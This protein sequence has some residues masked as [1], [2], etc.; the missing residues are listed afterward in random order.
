VDY[1]VNPWTW[2]AIA[3]FVGVIVAIF[4]KFRLEPM[5]QLPL[6][7][8]EDLG[9]AKISMPKIGRPLVE[10]RLT[11]ASNYVKTLFAKLITSSPATIQPNLTEMRD[12]LAKG[13]LFAQRS[14]RDKIIYL[15]DE[16]LMDPNF[17]VREDKHGST[18]IRFIQ[19]QDCKSYGTVDG[20]EYIGI[21]VN[22]SPNKFT[23]IQDKIYDALLGA[24][25]FMRLASVNQGKIKQ[26]DDRNKSLEGL[27]DKEHK[28]HAE[29]RSKLDRAMSALE[30]K[31]LSTTGE[32]KVP[33]GFMAK[34]KD[35]FTWPQLLTAA[36]AYLLSPLIIQSLASTQGWTIQP[37]ATS[38]LTALVTIAGFFV[39]PFLKK[40]LGRWL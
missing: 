13:Y 29:T 10:G 36:V 3:V 16:N 31:T 38:Y 24:L 14:G 28:E 19:T 21:Q 8:E 12:T 40:A 25:S 37:P 33:G 23:E 5:V 6:A 15:S 17:H 27:L 30:Q 9:I 4:Y 2:L 34:V 22:S 26:L 32:A 18:P 1:F 39:I 35:W 7:N 20:F 11:T